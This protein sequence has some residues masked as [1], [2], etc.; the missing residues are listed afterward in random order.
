MANKKISLWPR[1]RYGKQEDKLG[2]E[3]KTSLWQIRAVPFMLSEAS[4]NSS[5][6]MQH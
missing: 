3:R 6:Y 4:P 2:A 1:G 5:N